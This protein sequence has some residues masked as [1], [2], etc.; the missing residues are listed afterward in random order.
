M[1]NQP[2][3]RQPLVAFARSEI[4]LVVNHPQTQGKILRKFQSNR[5]I[6]S[7]ENRFQ[8]QLYSYIVLRQY[9]EVLHLGPTT[10]LFKS[11]FLKVAAVW[12]KKLE[13]P[14]IQNQPNFLMKQ[15]LVC[16]NRRKL[17][18][19]SWFLKKCVTILQI[20]SLILQFFFLLFRKISEI[21]P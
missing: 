17:G 11:F 7:G 16:P 5:S 12:T 19:L 3:R 6:R 21:G 4:Y 2:R 20:F 15:F 9:K 1:K 8:T 18:K 10:E 13:F 14:V